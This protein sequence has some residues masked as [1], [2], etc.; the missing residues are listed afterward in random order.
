MR[1]F[2][3]SRIKLHHMFWII[4]L[5]IIGIGAAEGYFTGAVRAAFAFLALVLACSLSVPLSSMGKPIVSLFGFKNS[6]VVA[7]LAP[8]VVWIIIV[9]VVRALGESAN[10]KINYYFKYKVGDEMRLFWQRMTQ[11][12]GLCVGV[13]N[14]GLYFFAFSVV[15]YVVGYPIIQ[16]SSD[17]DQNSFMLRTVGQL[18][19]SMKD[20]GMDK[21]V[22]PF[23]PGSKL[24]Y[25]A[26]DTIGLLYQNPKLET[27][28][29]NYPP[30][31]S[32]MERPEFAALATNRDFQKVWLSQSAV[33]E[34]LQEGPIQNL[35][36]NEQYYTVVQDA[37]GGDLN[38]LQEYLKTGVSPKFADI[39][40]LGKWHFAM[41]RSYK[42]ARRANISASPL[43]RLLVR[44][45]LESTMG[46]SV[47]TAF[48]DNKVLLRA[49]G[50]NK[51]ERVVRGTWKQNNRNTYTISLDE[52]GHQAKAEADVEEHTMNFKMFGLPLVFL[53]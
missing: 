38:D 18:S 53:K 14:G 52:G 12:V 22:T 47:L 1:A 42:L 34:L 19:E 4:A 40:I 9:L 50:T 6:V 39:L 20:T 41:N 16:V 29:G 10:Y 44:R 45:T 11:R 30:F 24:F 15:L 2:L 7:L 36:T 8:I 32:L 26:S 21:A 43:E 33:G 3:P 46:K 51:T 37:L 49:P 17:S 27:R 31:L 48:V 23:V 25:D 13:L 28:L 5:V 35:I